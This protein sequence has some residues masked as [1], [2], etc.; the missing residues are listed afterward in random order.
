[1]QIHLPRL[2]QA[3][4]RSFAPGPRRPPSPRTADRPRLRSRRSRNLPALARLRPDLPSALAGARRRATGART[5]P[6]LRRAPPCARVSCP[7]SLQSRAA[8][9][10]Q[11]TEQIS[12]AEDRTAAL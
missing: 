7:P 3:A 5:P 4:P 2:R 11:G 8:T 1:P 12:A 6:D 9:H 10:Q